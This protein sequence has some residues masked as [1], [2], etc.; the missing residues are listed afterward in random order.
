MNGCT[1]R[2]IA[3]H[4]ME[5]NEQWLERRYLRMEPE[6]IE[7]ETAEWLAEG[8]ASAC[9][10]APVPSARSHAESLEM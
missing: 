10:L 5:D 4:A 6:Q 1:V 2:L 7:Q 9:E 3:A 8:S